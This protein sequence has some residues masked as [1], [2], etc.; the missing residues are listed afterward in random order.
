MQGG[1]PSAQA[2]A[3]VTAVEK[4]EAEGLSAAEYDL[5]DQAAVA[6]SASWNPLKKGL[7]DREA[8]DMELRLSY[9]FAKY[10]THLASGRTDPVSVDSH[11]FVTPRKVDVA[12][13]MKQAVDSGKVEDTLRALAPQHPQYE[14]PV[15][16][17]H[18]TLPTNR[19]V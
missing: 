6:A 7:G 11:W 12:A 4:A 2:R 15:S 5:P 3:L 13:V 10:A 8:A 1:K 19:E 14:R 18:L 17:T 16:Y 9:A